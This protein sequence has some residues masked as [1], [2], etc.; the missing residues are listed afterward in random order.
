MGRRAGTR[1]H[2]DSR[3]D[4]SP[5]PTPRLVL[6][7]CR[8]ALRRT[9]HALETRQRDGSWV[10]TPVNLVVDGDQVG[11]RTWSRAGKAKRLRNFPD[12]R[13][14]GPTGAAV[15][16][17][18]AVRH[19]TP[20]RGRR[21]SPRRCTHR[22]ALPTSA[23]RRRAIRTQ[24]DALPD[25]ALRGRRHRFLLLPTGGFRSA[26]SFVVDP[27]ARQARITTAWFG[28]R[29]RMGIDM[30]TM[31]PSLA[32]IFAAGIYIGGGVLLAILIILLIVLLLRR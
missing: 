17:S 31:N 5:R 8:G 19:G 6:P 10:S 14:A 2:D 18:A 7:T 27:F 22:Q 29:L 28:R 30:R 20:A 9:M 25:A 13:F 16:R 32:T 12:V 21:G 3:R 23:R 15:P 24:A 26:T 1:R 4:F 11:F